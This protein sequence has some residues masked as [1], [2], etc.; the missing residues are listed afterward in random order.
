MSKGHI[1]V[2]LDGTLAEYHGW[3]GALIIGPPVPMMVERVKGWL[4]EGKDVR[5][6]TARVAPSDDREAVYKEIQDWCEQ[7]IGQRLEITCSKD[8]GTIEI[9]DDRAIGVVPN[10]GF[11]KIGEAIP[12]YEKLTDE[13]VGTFVLT[14]VTGMMANLPTDE[15]RKL[16][17]GTLVLAALDLM[18][19]IEG[20][21]VVAEFLLET[22]GNM[23]AANQPEKSE[24]I[25]PPG[26]VQ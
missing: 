17:A 12:D 2:D 20:D 1:L 4:A 8:Y 26:Y 19:S 10:T 6:F 11:V 13:A 18:R 5:I 3:Q 7:Q 24:L 16:A 21:E 25:L 14:T 22:V 23:Q 15:S 9:W